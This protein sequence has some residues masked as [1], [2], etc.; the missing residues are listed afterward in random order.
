MGRR[1]LGRHVDSG[2][3]RHRGRQHLGTGHTYGNNAAIECRMRCKCSNSAAFHAMQCSIEC[4]NYRQCNTVIG[5]DG[6]MPRCYVQHIHGGGT[7]S[8]ASVGDTADGGRKGRPAIASPRMAV[9]QILTSPGIVKR[10][11]RRVPAR[12]IGCPRGAVR[13][14]AGALGVLS[15]IMVVAECP[16]QSSR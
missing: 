2:Y 15:M 1:G 10:C 3:P 14:V 4:C 12:Q 5:A 11:R 13:V 6:T 16:A 8:R 9:T 7:T